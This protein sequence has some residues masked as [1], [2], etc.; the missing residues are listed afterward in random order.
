M[1]LTQAQCIKRGYF[2][3]P[4]VAISKAPPKVAPITPAIGR[5]WLLVA[6]PY[7]VG[8]EIKSHDILAACSAYFGVSINEMLSPRR[9]YGAA[10]DARFAFY[11]LACELTQKTLYS[12]GKGISR[13]R[14][15]VYKGAQ[16]AATDAVVMRAVNQIKAGLIKIE[17]PLAGL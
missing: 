6:T 14:T 11:Y 15:T 2:T 16:V 9:H 3:K 17:K 5:D 7:S 1:T 8:H 13:D 12:I 10:K 4:I